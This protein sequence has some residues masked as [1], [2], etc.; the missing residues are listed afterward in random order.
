[1]FGGAAKAEPQ[2]DPWPPTYRLPSGAI[3]VDASFKEPARQKLID[4]ATK[5]VAFLALALIVL[6]HEYWPWPE[7]VRLV[8]QFVAGAGPLPATEMAAAWL[9]VPTIGGAAM[10]G[11]FRLLLAALGI[12]RGTIAIEFQHDSL[13]IDGRAFDRRLAQ[14]F[15]LEPHHL[16]KIEGHNEKRLGRASNLY[17]HDA[18]TIILQYGERRIEIAQMLGTRPAAALLERVQELKKLPIESASDRRRGPDSARA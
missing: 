14:S 15:E 17:Y 8:L 16:G 5:A 12:D 9:F 13:L 3:R 7:L 11:M 2:H 10:V 18:Y 4:K 1:L 6:G